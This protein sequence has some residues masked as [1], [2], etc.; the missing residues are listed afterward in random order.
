MDFV[1]LPATIAAVCLV[2]ILTL[3]VCSAVNAENAKPDLAAERARV[4]EVIRASIQWAMTKDT[5]LLY[6]LF[7]HD[8]TLFWFS[9]D[10]GG[11]VR[12]FDAF[13][14][15]VEQVFLNPAFKADAARSS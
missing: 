10:A 6:S 14:Q 5:T 9:P 8:S 7:V 4:E 12:G 13:K 11:T 1:R 3:G 2:I 15:Q